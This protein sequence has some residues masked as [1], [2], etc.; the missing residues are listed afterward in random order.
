[1]IDPGKFTRRQ[2]N[3]AIFHDQWAEQIKV[4]N[5]NLQ[6]AF[7][8]PTATENQYIL[9]QFGPILNKKILDLGC[10]MGD[11]SIYFALQGAQVTAVDISAGMI[12]VTRRLAERHGVSDRVNAIQMPA[13]TL[14][15]PDQT[16]DM[17]YGNGVLHHVDITKT[18]GEVHRAIKPGAKACFIEPLSYNPMIWIY[19]YM[20]RAVRSEDEHPLSIADI[21]TITRTGSGNGSGVNW[22][23]ASHKEFHMCTLLIMVW[24]LI[25]EGI[26]PSKERYW[27]R[28]V[29]QGHRYEKAFRRLKAVDRFSHRTIPPTRWLSWNTVIFLE[30]Q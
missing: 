2:Q 17:V 11:A 18:I 20:A 5:I 14:L 15:F 3:E 9:K 1:M 19:R 7:N 29:E 26:H 12:D 21:K 30:K 22:K 25:G 16:F 10:G 4:E 24:F 8:S 6:A 23:T 13:E 28:F 27:K